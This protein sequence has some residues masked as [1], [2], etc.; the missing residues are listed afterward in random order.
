M[1]RKPPEVGLWAGTNQTRLPVAAEKTPDTAALWRRSSELDAS[2]PEVRKLLRF[3]SCLRG[4]Q[5][6]S[7][8]FVVL[9]VTQPLASFKGLP[10]HFR[11]CEPDLK[12]VLH[13]SLNPLCG[14]NLLQCILKSAQFNFSFLLSI[15]QFL[16]VPSGCPLFQKDCYRRKK[17]AAVLI[18]LILC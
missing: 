8:S 18:F 7:L 13:H 10:S 6:P 2:G 1:G 16:S 5:A 15:N 14:D 3:P 11:P 4:A 12:A 17:N 9:S